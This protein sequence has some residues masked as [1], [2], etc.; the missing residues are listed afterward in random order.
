MKNNKLKKRIQLIA[1]WLISL[2]IIGVVL[3]LVE[4]I[5]CEK[6]AER[7]VRNQADT[8]AEQLPTIYENDVYERIASQKKSDAKIKTLALAMEKK[9][10]ITEAKGLLDDYVKASDFNGL[11]ICDSKGKILYQ[12][13]DIGDA[14]IMESLISTAY[15]DVSDDMY[16]AFLDATDDYSD[17]L[18]SGQGFLEKDE[19]Y[20]NVW[21]IKDGKWYAVANFCLS[22]EEQKM[23][24]YFSWSDVLSQYVVGKTGFVI[25]ID[26]QSGTILQYSDYEML[27]HNID[28]IGLVIDGTNH[29][30]SLEE[31]KNTFSDNDSV[32]CLRNGKDKYHVTRIHQEGVLMLA[33]LPHVEIKSEV[34]SAVNT[35]MLLF[36][37]AT[38]VIVL[39]VFFH[40][41]N[42]EDTRENKGKKVWNKTLYGKIMIVS[43]LTLIITIICGV[44]L[45][46]LL[47]HAG[48]YTGNEQKARSA[49]YEYSEVISMKQELQNWFKEDCKTRARIAETVLENTKEEY[50][51][52]EFLQELSESLKSSYIYIYDTKGKISLTNSPYKNVTIGSDSPFY[53]LL[54][55]RSEYVSDFEKDEETGKNR[56]RAGV[57]RM[58]HENTCTGFIILETGAEEIKSIT[59]NLGYSNIFKRFCAQDKT[60]FLVV[61]HEEL[62]IDYMAVINGN[63]YEE[64]FEEGYNDNYSVEILGINEKAQNKLHDKYNGSMKVSGNDYYVAIREE[65]DKLFIILTPQMFVTSGL[66]VHIILEIVSMLLYTILLICISCVEKEGEVTKPVESEES[67]AAELAEE[68]SNQKN[69]DL[70]AILSNLTNKNKPYFEERWAKDSVKWKDKTPDEKFTNA[71][72]VVFLLTLVSIAIQYALAGQNSVWYYCFK[73]DWDTGV[74]LHTITSCLICISSLI[75]AKT[76]IHKI[77]YFIA[78]AAGSRGETICHLFDSFLGY[79][80]VIAGILLCLSNC[81]VNLKTLTI[82]SGVAGVVFGIGCQNIVADI[83][84][85]ILMCFEGVV[86][87]GDFVMYNNK[88]GVVLSIGV[89]TT[90]LR[91]FGEIT[92]VRNNDFKN[93]VDYPDG[94]R[95]RALAYITID[96]KESL[97]RVEAVLDRE[98]PVINEH[99]ASLSDEPVVGPKYR[100]V[101]QISENGVTL[102]FALFCPNAYTY[103]LLRQLNRELKYMCER[104]GINLAMTQVVVNEPVAYPDLTLTEEKES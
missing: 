64:Y 47:L 19:T 81:G 62:T 98:L 10:N 16:D 49:V 72:F 66:I 6:E 77:L 102:S 17:L 4:N 23:R 37:L 1:A 9:G 96:L 27:G 97:E 48:V 99:L 87:A 38:G 53:S 26:E 91:W 52:E 30:A 50:I 82:T 101:S 43:L 36:F 21:K 94:R 35:W 11:A 69:D 93:F 57:S 95:N 65:S 84:A 46:A 78:R 25:T 89:R 67:E 7:S 32:I 45:D 71:L 68:D 14:T 59:K 40:I 41:G 55:G 74:N 83:L 79:F 22:E 8:I 5:I 60:M 3:V 76:V 42:P 31:L 88:P 100:G 86:R 28:E 34:V 13:G 104:N 85:G 2:V 20:Y 18:L 12:S 75:I 29:I 15:D 54:E 70:L 103:W 44:F 58:D 51:T 39:F 56:V 61:N 63:T 90:R 73:S 33:V 92:I 80:L 24:R